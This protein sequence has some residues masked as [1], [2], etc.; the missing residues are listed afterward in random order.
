VKWGYPVPLTTEDQATQASAPTVSAPAEASATSAVGSP[1]SAA[2]PT[3]SRQQ[4]EATLS[5]FQIDSETLQEWEAQLALRIPVG[6]DGYKQ[7]TQQ[8]L[9]LFKNIRKHLALGRSLEQ[10]RQL[11]SLPASDSSYVEAAPASASSRPSAAK[12]SSPSVQASSSA[13]SAYMSAPKLDKQAFQAPPQ[14]APEKPIAESRPQP[15]AGFSTPAPASAPVASAG[16]SLSASIAPVAE[17]P[18]AVLPM[19]IG[20]Q[21]IVP[22]LERLVDEKEGL[23]Q[24]LLEAEKLNSHL[25]NVNSVFHKRVKALE[26]EMEAL[27]HRSNEA[28]QVQW[29]EEKTRLQ[30]QL[31]EVEKQR[32]GQEETLAQAQAEQQRLQEQAARLKRSLAYLQEGLPADAFCGQWQQEL[33][34]VHI[35]FDQ[36]GLNIEAKLQRVETVQEPPSR[37]FA[38]CTV[39]Q[40]RYAYEQNPLWSRQEEW[41]LAY[42]QDKR[43][44]GEARLDF[45]LDGVSV[46]RA[47]YQMTCTRLGAV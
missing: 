10:I 26:A 27:T 1:S 28:A 9:N 19:G 15:V 37:L 6:P 40:R 29:M 16:A 33:S 5:R 11:L 13:R 31:L 14:A 25:Y 36:F 17:T 47:I 44:V 2:P 38:N 45:I 46:A 42:Q 12:E 18:L 22:L 32:L 34:L 7:Y 35:E 21:Q 24:K 43:L 20:Q 41:V 39:L 23:H 8:H 30:R 4:V 3:V